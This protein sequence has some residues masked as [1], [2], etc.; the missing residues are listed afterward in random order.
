MSIE[1]QV[2]ECK[3]IERE[4]GSKGRPSRAATTRGKQKAGGLTVVNPLEGVVRRVQDPFSKVL[5]S[6]SPG[7][8]LSKGGLSGA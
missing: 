4:G 7:Q 1:R 5:H 8:F 3:A 2:G 6:L